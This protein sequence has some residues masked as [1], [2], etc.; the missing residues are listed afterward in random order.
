MGKTVSFAALTFAED[1]SENIHQLL[2][3]LTKTI[4]P[5]SGFLPV[6]GVD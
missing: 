2:G 4:L 3:F 1:G 6:F 5:G